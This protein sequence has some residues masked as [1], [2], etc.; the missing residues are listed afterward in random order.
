M[1]TVSLEYQPNDRWNTV[2]KVI[3]VDRDYRQGNGYILEPFARGLAQ[4]VADDTTW[5]DH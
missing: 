3:G 1:R 5:C 4:P 2:L